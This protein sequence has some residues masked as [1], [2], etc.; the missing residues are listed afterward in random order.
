MLFRHFKE[1]SDAEKLEKEKSWQQV[2]VKLE[3]DQKGID[4]EIL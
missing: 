4:I 2:T 3:E 1:L